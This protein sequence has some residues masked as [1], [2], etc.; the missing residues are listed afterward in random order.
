MVPTSAPT[1][2]PTKASA[3]ETLLYNIIGAGITVVGVTVTVLGLNGMKWYQTQ[4]G[5]PQPWKMTRTVF[6]KWFGTLFLWG[7][8]QMMMLSAV[9]DYQLSC[10]A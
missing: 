2:G 3:Q 1:A 9:S 6:V 5:A 10:Q 8:G 4:S 7:V